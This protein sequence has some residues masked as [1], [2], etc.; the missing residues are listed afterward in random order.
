MRKYLAEVI[1]AFALV[2]TGCGAIVVN[3][4]YGGALGHV[5][6][7]LVFGL[8]V[9][10]LIYAVGN[11]SGAHFN[12]AVT[13]GFFF[14]K[15]LPGREVPPYLASEL[16]G[17]LGA[18]LLL[19][20][21]FPAHPTLGATLPGDSLVTVLVMEIVLSFIL[22]FVILNVSTGAMEKGIMAGAAIG[23]T[24]MLCALFGG[25]VSGASLNPARSL[26]PALVSG[27]LAHSW[28][29]VVAPIIGTALA[30][31][32]CRFIQGKACC[33]VSE[34]LAAEGNCTECP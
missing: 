27:Q 10:A 6:I 29:Y 28:L 26:G 7:C 21:M 14:A 18:A 34:K 9:M 1:G 16:G 4:Q 17:A 31:P 25:P 5:G 20:L 3:D 2:F 19:K 23:A 15:R 24:V 12:P 30:S 13:L 32:T 33:F 11:I 22:M 8:V